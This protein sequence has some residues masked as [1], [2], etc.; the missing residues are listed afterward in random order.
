[1]QPHPFKLIIAQCARV[2]FFYYGLTSKRFAHVLFWGLSVSLYLA[3]FQLSPLT[4]VLV[5]YVELV[6]LLHCRELHA[7]N[8]C[9]CV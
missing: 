7:V 3:E 1:M 2:F 6:A 9:A 4:K 5:Q 8:K